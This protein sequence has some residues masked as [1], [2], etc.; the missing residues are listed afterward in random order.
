MAENKKHD[1]KAENKKHDYKRDLIVEGVAAGVEEVAGKMGGILA[2]LAAG[3][4]YDHPKEI[5]E[6]QKIY[7]ESQDALDHTKVSPHDAV[8]LEKNAKELREQFVEGQTNYAESQDDLSG[9][10]VDYEDAP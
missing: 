8:K 1:Y 7:A 2:G 5:K 10:N 4:A 6:G 9:T 3:M